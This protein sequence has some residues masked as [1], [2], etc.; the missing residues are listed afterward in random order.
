MSDGDKPSHPWYPFRMRWPVTIDEAKREQGSIRENVR[1]EPLRKPPRF[2]AGVDVAFSGSRMV[3]VASVFHYPEM[4]PTED[5]LAV[6]KI[7]FPY[8]PGYLS[9]REGPAIIGAMEKLGM[10]PDVVLVDGQGI[11]HPRGAGIAS[12]IGVLLNLPTVGCAK[13]RLIGGYEE[14]GVKKGQWSPLK[15]DDGIVGVVMRTRDGVKPLFVSPGHLITLRESIE[16][17]LTCCTNYRIPEPL[18]RADRLSKERRRV[19]SRDREEKSPLKFFI[20]LNLP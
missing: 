15:L 16:I 2:V 5:A 7:P 13:S 17:V 6:A 3:G 10:K 14:P 19:L 12:H 8:I 20:D 1:I 9:F 18:R 11:A 4:T